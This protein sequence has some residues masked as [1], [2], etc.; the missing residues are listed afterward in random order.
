MM[1]TRGCLCTNHPYDMY[2]DHASGGFHLMSCLKDVPTLKGD[3]YSEW[4]KKVDMTLVCVEVDW[5]LEKP[6]PVKHSEPVRDANDDDD[7][8]EKKKW[9]HATVE[10]SYSISNQNWVN[11]NKKC[12]SFIKNTIETSIMGLNCRVHFRRGDAKKGYYTQ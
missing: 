2:K 5:I 11:A 7:A 12:L 8:W 10:M 4:N 3:N 9:D 1:I 6:Q